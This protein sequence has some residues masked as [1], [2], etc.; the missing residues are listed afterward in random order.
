MLSTVQT[1]RLFLLYSLGKFE[2][3]L[4]EQVSVPEEYLCISRAAQ[5]SW[6]NVMVQLHCSQ[7]ALQLIGI[8]LCCTALRSL[9]VP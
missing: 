6:S 5:L 3:R 7:Y 4:K 8:S 9:S 1:A 2:C